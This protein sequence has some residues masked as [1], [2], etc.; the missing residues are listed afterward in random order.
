MKFPWQGR[1][2][3]S[4]TLSTSADAYDFMVKKKRA[5]TNTCAYLKMKCKKKGS[6]FLYFIENTLFVANSPLLGVIFSGMFFSTIL[7]AVSVQS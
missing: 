6:V 1:W 3:A 2:C 4:V 5:A 7:S